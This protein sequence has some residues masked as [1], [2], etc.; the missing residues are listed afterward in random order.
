MNSLYIIIF[1]IGTNI[2]IL[3]L[4]S[5]AEVLKIIKFERLRE[6]D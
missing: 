3:Q 1:E 6:S 5:I 4:V 2:Y